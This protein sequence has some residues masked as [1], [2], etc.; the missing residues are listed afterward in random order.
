MDLPLRGDEPQQHAAGQQ[1]HRRGD[2]QAAGEYAA[3][4]DGGAEDDDQFQTE[5]AVHGLS[6]PAGSS[7][8]SVVDGHR[9]GCC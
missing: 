5:Q 2:P 4:Q 1:Q 6:S 9:P 3:G 7:G 8:G